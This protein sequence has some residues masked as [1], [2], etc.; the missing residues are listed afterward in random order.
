MNLYDARFKNKSTITIAG[1]SQSGKTTLVE[2]I[3]RNK[4]ELFVEPITNVHWF[5]AYPPSEKIDGVQYIIGIPT[6]NEIEPHS[7]VIID[8]F[9]KELATSNEL[10]SLMTKAVHHLPMTLIYI[11]QNIFQKGIDT[12]TRRLNT[13]YL[14]V[15]KNPHDRAQVDYI[16]RQM[17][18][19]DK[20]FL[21]RSFED[22]TMKQP[23]SYLFIDCHQTTPD[24][25]RVRTNIVGE[26]IMKVYVP[27]SML[28]SA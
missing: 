22:A 15:F 5:C 9:M 11:T 10:T 26:G 1:P 3:V 18:P 16:G 4:D 24:E 7:L 20:N 27:P 12:K 28:L 13:N 2:K 19:R 23:H 14:I 25:I 17:Y 21:S 6:I 8:D